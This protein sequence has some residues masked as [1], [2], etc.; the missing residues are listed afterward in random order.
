MMTEIKVNIGSDN[1]LTAPSHYLNQ[2][3]LLISEV[4]WHSPGAISQRVPQ[5]FLCIMSLKIIF[6]KLLPHFSGVRL[7]LPGL[8]G[9]QCLRRAVKLNKQT[10]SLLSI[11]SLTHSLLSILSLTHSL[12]PLHSLTHPPTH[13]LLH[14]LTHS[15]LSILSLTHSPTHSSPFTHSLLSIHSLLSMLSL[16]SLTHRLTH[17]VNELMFKYYFC[18]YENSW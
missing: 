16:L 15:L 2:S 9:H 13:S 11:L 7:W 8:Y 1:G 10:R 4:L 5:L 17:G 12:T 14:S 18:L 6:G 3:W